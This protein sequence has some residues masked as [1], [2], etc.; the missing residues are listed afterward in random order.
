MASHST[1]HIASAVLGSVYSRSHTDGVCVLCVSLND[2]TMRP[3]ALPLSAIGG[4]VPSDSAL[5]K[6][7]GPSRTVDAEWGHAPPRHMV[8]D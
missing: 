7:G 2:Y 4:R 1:I 8:Y 6:A 5:R 3:D